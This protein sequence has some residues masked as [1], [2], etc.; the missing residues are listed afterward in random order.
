MDGKVQSGFTY[1]QE[2][3]SL[4]LHE[5]L[6]RAIAPFSADAASCSLCEEKRTENARA[7]GVFLACHGPR[8]IR[9]ASCSGAAVIL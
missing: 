9:A 2:T 7:G 4:T 1:P 5:R 8:W 6:L 3:I